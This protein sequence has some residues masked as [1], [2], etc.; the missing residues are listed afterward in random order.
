MF[1]IFLVFVENC[2]KKER[3]WTE[4]GVCIPGV[5]LDPTLCWL[6]HLREVPDPPLLWNRMVQGSETGFRLV[7]LLPMLLLFCSIWKG[8]NFIIMLWLK[9]LQQNPFSKTCNNVNVMTSHMTLYDCH[10]TLQY[11]YL[12]LDMRYR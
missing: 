5:P 12:C 1:T 11:V 2:M 6:P 3:I 10:M 9:L 8:H 7:L 4:S